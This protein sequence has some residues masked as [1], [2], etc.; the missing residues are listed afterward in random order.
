MD[1]DHLFQ[2]KEIDAIL[3]AAARLQTEDEQDKAKAQQG[4]S[5]KELEEIAA[6][7]GIDPSYVRQA[8]FLGNEEDFDEKRFHLFGAPTKIRERFVLERSLNREERENLIPSIR[9]TLGADGYSESLSD[10]LNWRS[11]KSRRSH[12]QSSVSVLSEGGKS[13][14]QV[15]SKD[16]FVGFMMHYLAVLPVLLIGL[17]VMSNIGFT[18]E[19]IGITITILATLILVARFGYSKYHDHKSEKIQRVKKAIKSAAKKEIEEKPASAQINLDNLDYSS[20]NEE[21]ISQ[22]RIETK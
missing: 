16:W 3:K 9:D 8:A 7:S 22:T 4:L 21:R 12:P 6:E 1:K 15:E 10:S 17:S 2:G 18:A 14:V 11:V 5:L 19:L 13:I 20:E